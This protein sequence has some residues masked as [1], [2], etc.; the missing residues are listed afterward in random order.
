MTFGIYQ[1]RNILNDKRYIGSAIGKGGV[2]KRWN[3]HK[4]KLNTNKHHSIKL[5]NAWNKYGESAFVFELVQ[6]HVKLTYVSQKE[7]KE[8]VL[9]SEQKWLDELL[10]ASANDARFHQLGYNISRNAANP[11]LGRKATIATRKKMSVAHSGEKNHFFGKTHTKAARQKIRVSKLG[12]K[13]APRH[14]KLTI[15]QVVEI[16]KLLSDGAKQHSLAVYFGVNQATISNIANN[17]TW[18][19][20]SV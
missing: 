15:E 11:M 12:K 3:E 14:T 8:I 6:E 17:K 9:R 19:N 7:W 20:I 10:F 5:Q 1:I 18:S 13:H 2:L 16:K 4:R